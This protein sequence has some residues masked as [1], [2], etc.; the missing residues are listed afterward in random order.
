MTN[1]KGKLKVDIL[2]DPSFLPLYEISAPT[3]ATCYLRFSQ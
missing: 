2:P 3:G 1:L